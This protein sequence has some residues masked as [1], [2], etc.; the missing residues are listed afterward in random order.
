MYMSYLKRII[1]ICLVGITGSIAGQKK[2]TGSVLSSDQIIKSFKNESTMQISSIPLF[3]N[4]KN[5]VL[6]ILSPEKN[7]IWET[8]FE[9]NG[10][11]RIVDIINYSDQ[12]FYIT[13]YKIINSRE[14]DITLF[15]LNKEDG[16]I[17]E[18]IYR[19]KGIEIPR[20]ITKTKDNALI[21]GGYAANCKEKYYKILK[22]DLHLIKVQSNGNRI[23]VKTLGLKKIDED[24]L[25][26][27]ITDNNELLIA[28]KRKSFRDQLFLTK[29]DQFGNIS[30]QNT[31]NIGERIKVAKIQTRAEEKLFT[32]TSSVI[33]YEIKNEKLYKNDVELVMDY[34]GSRKKITTLSTEELNFRP[35][36]K[37]THGIKKIRVGVI[38]P[39]TLNLRQSP[40]LNAGVVASMQQG[41]EVEIVQ[42][43]N[44]KQKINN[45]NDYWYLLKINGDTTGWAYGHFID[46]VK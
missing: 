26:L 17:W 38:K 29:I 30:W 25:D 7:T 34:G 22:N 4:K 35:T 44:N 27:A 45:M 18:K 1:F 31:Y 20:R 28:G 37:F 13:G 2:E 39:R 36:E 3:N 33:D 41:T 21:I 46:I 24:L 15:K 9:I 16:L 14:Y 43:T 23:W 40:T 19:H 6:K 11:T 42:K 10:R 12:E 32:V 8:N 5:I